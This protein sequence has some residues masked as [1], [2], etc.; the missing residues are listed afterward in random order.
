MSRQA[1]YDAYGM[2]SH[3]TGQYEINYLVSLELDGS[4]DIL[5]LWPEPAKS[6]PGFRQID[7]V[8]NYLY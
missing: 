6:T 5:K 7:L 3:T 2:L 8:E 4:N 1:V